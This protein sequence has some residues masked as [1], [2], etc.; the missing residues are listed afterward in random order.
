[1]LSTDVCGGETHDEV[2]DQP[3]PGSPRSVPVTIRSPV[4]LQDDI[5]VG[6]LVEVATD[7]DQHYYGVVRWIGIIDGKLYI[8]VP[9]IN[10]Y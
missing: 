3:P 10:I 4:D 6:S 2:Y 9:I 7:V 1:M 5:G 8:L